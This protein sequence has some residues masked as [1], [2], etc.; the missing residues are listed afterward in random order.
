MKCPICDSK[1]KPMGD[2]TVYLIILGGNTDP[3]RTDNM[4]EIH[5][6]IHKW[7][8]YT[9]HP[10]DGPQEEIE[11]AKLLCKECEKDLIR[12]LGEVI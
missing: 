7:P 1:F 9:R 6:R 3:F 5:V 4:A 12:K 10:I 11:G 2:G 8:I